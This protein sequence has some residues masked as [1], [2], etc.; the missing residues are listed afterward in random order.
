M[1]KSSQIGQLFKLMSAVKSANY[2]KSSIAVAEYF[3]EISGFGNF[4]EVPTSFFHI[5]TGY[6]KFI[7]LRIYA[8]QQIHMKLLLFFS[9][10]L[11]K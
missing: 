3:V 6:W 11:S 4:R 2:F 9:S 8:V 5:L 10:L 7:L 1:Q